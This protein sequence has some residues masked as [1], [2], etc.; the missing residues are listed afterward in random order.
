MNL[1]ITATPLY[2]GQLSSF[3]K[4]VV[5]ERFLL[6]LVPH[7]IIIKSLKAYLGTKATAEWHKLQFAVNECQWIS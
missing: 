5:V 7:K 4:V 3:L 1:P 2:N 6:Q